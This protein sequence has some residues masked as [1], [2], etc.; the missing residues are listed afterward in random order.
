MSKVICR[1]NFM[2]MWSTCKC[3]TIPLNWIFWNFSA[4]F[5]RVNI[6]H[7]IH[8]P[9]IFEAKKINIVQQGAPR[10]KIRK[11]TLFLFIF[12]TFTTRIS[13]F[14]KI[15]IPNINCLCLYFSIQ[16]DFSVPAWPV[17]PGMGQQHSPDQ[18]HRGTCKYPHFTLSLKWC[19]PVG[20]GGGGWRGGEPCTNVNTGMCRWHGLRFQSFWY[21]CMGSWIYYFFTE[22]SA[23][24]LY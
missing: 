7:H 5:W 13:L 10:T 23:I 3:V 24:L 9:W 14:M 1:R 16:A 21:I 15:F 4:I 6:E 12:F 8:N 18:L 2:E 17:R 19:T 20:R 22:L 11:C